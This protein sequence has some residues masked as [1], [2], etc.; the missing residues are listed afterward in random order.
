MGDAHIRVE[1]LFFN[2]FLPTFVNEFKDHLVNVNRM[3]KEH[4]S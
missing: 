2:S 4:Y 3:M 1:E